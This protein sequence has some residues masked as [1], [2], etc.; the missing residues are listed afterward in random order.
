MLTKID[1]SFDVSFSSAPFV[2]SRFRVFLSDVSSK[3]LQKTLY[4]KIASK[5][6]YKKNEQKNPKPYFSRFFFITFLGVSRFSVR[7]VQKHEKKLE[8]KLEKKSDQLTSPGTR[9]LFWLRGTNQPRQA[10]RSVVRGP[11][12]VVRRPSAVGGSGFFLVRVL[13]SAQCPVP[14]PLAPCTCT[15]TPS[16]PISISISISISNAISH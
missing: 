16:H 7:G 6:F 13:P 5:S 9:V 2:L 12:S 1:K 8:K 15:C 4:K 11:W 10:P 14:V 3:A